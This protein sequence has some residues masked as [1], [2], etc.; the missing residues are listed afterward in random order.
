MLDLTPTLVKECRSVRG[1]CLVTDPTI[2]VGT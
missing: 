2:H 1:M